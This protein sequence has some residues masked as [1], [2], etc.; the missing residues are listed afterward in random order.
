M[1]VNKQTGLAGAIIVLLLLWLNRRQERVT[2]TFQPA[3]DW[4][5]VWTWTGGTV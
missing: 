2:T 5:D 1:N 3:P 4:W